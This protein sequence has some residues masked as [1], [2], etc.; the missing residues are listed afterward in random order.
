[1]VSRNGAPLKLFRLIFQQRFLHSLALLLRS[2]TEVCVV[3]RLVQFRY[4]GRNDQKPCNVLMQVV[5]I[6]EVTTD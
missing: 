4:N 1:M 3:N 5:E 2:G 6:R